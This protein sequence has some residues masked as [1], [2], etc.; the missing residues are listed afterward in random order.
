MVAEAI[1][2][3]FFAECGRDGRGPR[4]LL[5]SLIKEHFASVPQMDMQVRMLAMDIAMAKTL[6]Q[7][8]AL[9][10]KLLGVVSRVM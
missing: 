1:V 5:L 9:A 7:A 8:S 4:A 10:D 6:E 2:E 3:T